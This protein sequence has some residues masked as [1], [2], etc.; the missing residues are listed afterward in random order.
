MKLRLLP[1]T[2]VLLAA[3]TPQILKDAPPPIEIL[4]DKPA[5]DQ[6][7]LPIIK[8]EQIAIDPGKAAENYREILKLAPDDNTKHE[9]M[10]RL[11]DLQVQIED[12]KGID[13]DSEKALRD[14]VKLYNDLLYS[15]PDDKE[16]A[17]VFYQ[18]ARAY[19]GLGEP[20]AAIETLE[21]L[22]RRHPDS[23]LA[24]DAHFRRAELLF[25][26]RRYAEAEVEYKTV[27]DLKDGT[28]FF[29]PAQ[30]KFGWARYKQSNYE[31]ALEVFVAILDRELPQGELFEVKPALD[32][33]DP[34]KSDLARDAVRVMS[35]SLAAMGGGKAANDYLAAK[36]DPRF[37]PLIYT[38]L[39]ELL[40][41]K[42]RYTDSAEAYAAF[43]ERYPKHRH[44]PDFQSKVIAAYSEG[45]FNDLVVREK[46]R[47][48]TV[49][50]PAAPY[51]G[52]QT[53]RAD[54]LKELRK[55]YEDLG[56]HYFAKAQAGGKLEP[57]AASAQTTSTLPPIIRYKD[58]DGFLTAGRWYRRVLEVFP[59]D[60]QRAEMNFMLGESLLNGGKTLDGANELMRTAYDYPPPNNRVNEA[61]YG[62]VL[63]YQQHA[64][65]VPPA[66]RPAALRLAIE[67]SLK[68]ADKL[69]A[70]PEVYPVLTRTAEDLFELKEYELVVGVAGRVINASR[71]VDYLLRRTAWSV[72]GD[73]QFALKKYDLA[74]LAFSEELKLTPKNSPAYAETTE[75]LAAAIY[76]Q[77]EA[78]RDAGDLR[79][80]AEQFLRVAKVTPTA[81]I[82]STAEYDGATMLIKLEDWPAAVAV[83][84]GFRKSFPSHALEADVDKKLAV[85]Y[86]KDN[87]PVQAA[88]VYLRI[89]QRLSETPEVRREA[90]WLSATLFDQGKDINGAAGAYEFYVVNFPRPLDRA[91]DARQRLADVAKD[92]GDTVNRLRWL[93]EIIAADESAGAER[94]DKS[95]AM[96]ATAALD[97][98]RLSAIDMKALRLTAPVEKSLPR[99]RQAMEAA[100]QAL[101]KAANYG[102]AEITTAATYEL[103]LIYQDFAKSLM[104]SERPKKLSELE[105]EQYNTLLEE[106]AFPFEE[107]AIQTFETN[108][109]RISQGVYDE[110]IAKSYKALAQ[111]APAKYGKREKGEDSYATLK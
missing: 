43:T 6:N 85:A 93:R 79:K 80:A 4:E 49:Y 97:V 76:K 50:D 104:D 19:Q 2:T 111:I 46:E 78:A 9:S 77:G 91:M 32:A 67:A 101:S 81:K 72:T 35:L 88:Q 52:G 86:Q 21:K 70:H 15:R 33:V 48:A 36:G 94:S 110:W 30:Y 37:Y 3:C 38:A 41:E 16:N 58:K 12:A 60:R 28:P 89:A 59:E 92:R 1:L 96:G 103:G 99:K 75:Q 87:K 7:V 22:T 29:E 55:H 74:E 24:G 18:L 20:D 102:Y 23:E 40:L 108:L 95:K 56:K 61:A 8:S 51:W 65:D 31:G 10:R 107:K 105:L 73:S 106:Q 64:R 90:G 57:A 53:V 69:V 47:Y 62:A 100:I 54:V 13:G 26:R 44:A 14:S 39:G 42:R 63:A 17:R 45:G 11:A 83:L 25:S 27:M 34:R 5:P 71:P 68:M 66:E 109:K 98:G 82:R 84:E